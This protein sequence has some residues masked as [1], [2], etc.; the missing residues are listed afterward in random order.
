MCRVRVRLTGGVLRTVST[1]LG[2]MGQRDWL[3]GGNWLYVEHRH[4][5]HG[6]VGLQCESAG[7]ESCIPVSALPVVHRTIG[8]E[9]SSHSASTP[10]LLCNGCVSL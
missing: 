2:C 8:S 6:A 3:Y 10:F 5:L 1:D 4:W 9:Q 7:G